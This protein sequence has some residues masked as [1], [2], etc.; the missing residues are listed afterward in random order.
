MAAYGLLLIL[1]FATI[2]DRRLLWFSVT[3][4]LALLAL[5]LFRAE[6]EGVPAPWNRSADAPVAPASGSPDASAE[7]RL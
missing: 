2:T 6:A 1:T 5:T 3:V 4:L 7:N